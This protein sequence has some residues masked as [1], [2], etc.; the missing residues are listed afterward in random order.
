MFDD[1]TNDNHA[2][3]QYLYYRMKLKPVSGFYEYVKV[4][5]GYMKIN[6]D[7]KLCFSISK[8]KSSIEKK[9]VTIMNIKWKWIQ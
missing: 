3:K 6:V 1:N 5:F 7:V 9:I 4:S 2:K 8:L